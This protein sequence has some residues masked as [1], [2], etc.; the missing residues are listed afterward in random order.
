MS[1]EREAKITQ[2]A[3]AIHA[4]GRHVTKAA[5]YALI[6]GHKPDIAP[7]IDA[8]WAAHPEAAG[9][10]AVAA[11]PDGAP[12]EAQAAVQVPPGRQPVP[13]LPACAAAYREARGALE[14]AEQRVQ[15][16]AQAWSEAKYAAREATARLQEASRRARQAPAH[17]LLAALTAVEQAQAGLAALV[18]EAQAARAADD[19]TYRPEGL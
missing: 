16:A 17:E 8:W 13:R 14:Q 7:V 4:E 11:P 18:G 10:V 1:P 5:V 3:D 2:A 19:F 6:K 12:A 15:E 9:A